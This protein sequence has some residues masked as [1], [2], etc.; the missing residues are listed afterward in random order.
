MCV[1]QDVHR[2]NMCQTGF[3]TDSAVAALYHTITGHI[4]MQLSIIG[5]LDNCA[6]DECVYLVGVMREGV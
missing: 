2:T 6:V 4:C 5:R 3:A 1:G